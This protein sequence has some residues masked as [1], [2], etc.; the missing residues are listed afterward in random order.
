MKL[1][2]VLIA[3]LLLA[4][5]VALAAPG[6]VSETVSLRA[7]PGFGFPVVD[8]IPAG[9]RVYIQ[10]CLK[11]HAW[12]DVSWSDDRGWVSSQYL[13][14]LYRDR[15]VYLPDYV[16]EI[17]VPIVPFVIGSYWAN[18][19]SGRPWYPR[20]AYWSNY[21]NT[22]A[23]DAT[24]MRVG[25]ATARIGRAAAVRDSAAP[26]GRTRAGVAGATREQGIAGSPGARELQTREAQGRAAEAAANARMRRE[27]RANMPHQNVAGRPARMQPPARS[28][29]APRVFANPAAQRAVPTPHI[30]RP[31]VGPRPPMSAHAQFSAPRAAAPPAAP[32]VGGVPRINAAPAA[33]HGGGGVMRGG[34][35]PHGHERH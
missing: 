5:S 3:A 27:N 9:S 19:Y 14:Y 26:G 7:G 13:E 24:R 32:H 18:Y 11:G 16:D 6:I 31:N 17:D 25:Q 1:K 15:Y 22:H 28:P 34:G 33:P 12:C 30:A 10:G 20:R 2:G 8:R 4:P 23:S 21:W 29:A 35:G